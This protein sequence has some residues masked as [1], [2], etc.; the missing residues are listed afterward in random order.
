MKSQENSRRQ[1]LVRGLV[2]VAVLP[3]AGAM[4]SATASAA[5]LKPLP[6]TNPQAVALK[7]VTDAKK[8]VGVKP[9]SNCANCSLFQAATKACGIFPGFAVAPAGWCSAWAKKA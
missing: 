5:A 4:L 8:G 6:A 2:S 9:G 3:F 1:F 7:Y